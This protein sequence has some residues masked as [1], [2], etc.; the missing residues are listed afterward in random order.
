MPNHLL[1][2]I[3]VVFALSLPS[4]VVLAAY[5]GNAE[6]I[7]RGN[8]SNCVTR[9]VGAEVTLHTRR[10]LMAENQAEG[11]AAANNAYNTTQRMPHSTT[12]NFVGVQ[13]YRSGQEGC[14]ATVKTLNY[15]EHGY[16]VIIHA[17]RVNAPAVNIVRAFGRSDWGTD[18]HLVEAVLGDIQHS[19][20]PNTLA[21]LEAIQLPPFQ[22]G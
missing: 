2:L 1:T 15:P 8:F 18:L 22:R 3:A 14:E 10:A 17:M 5:A 4:F 16:G 6:A 9:G 13:N 19:R 20:F 11:V 12:F 21:H 7:T